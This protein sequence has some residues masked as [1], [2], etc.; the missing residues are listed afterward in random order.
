MRR[1]AGA[2][3][4]GV[5]HATLECI[6]QGGG[7]CPDPAPAAAAPYENPAFPNKASFLVPGI[8]AGGQNNHVIGFYNSLVFAPGSYTFVVCVDAGR[9]VREDNERDNCARFV[10]RVRGRP[11]G[12][13]GLTSNNSG[14]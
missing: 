4:A 13:G 8:A 2:D 9:E 3:A 10:K 6:A 11:A 14:N 7:S 5:S 1:G 12:P